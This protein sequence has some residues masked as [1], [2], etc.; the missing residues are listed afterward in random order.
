MHGDAH[1]HLDKKLQTP[2]AETRVVYDRRAFDLADSIL[3]QP[4]CRLF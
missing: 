2:C 3:S 1:L 4:V